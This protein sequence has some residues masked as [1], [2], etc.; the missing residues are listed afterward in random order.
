M[1]MAAVDGIQNK[2]HPGPSLDRD[3]YTPEQLSTSFQPVPASLS[4]SLTA[5]EEDGEF[6][7]RGDVFTP[8]FIQAWI[9]HKRIMD[10]DSLRRHPHP[11]EIAA[12]FEM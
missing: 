5:L 8:E 3:P 6:L 11:L 7:L 9:A 4:I 2:I 10:V 1:L 12:Y